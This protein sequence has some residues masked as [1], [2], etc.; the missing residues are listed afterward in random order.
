VVKFS[1]G[2]GLSAQP[3]RRTYPIFICAE[4]FRAMSYHPFASESF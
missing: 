4:A 1:C 3:S 2:L